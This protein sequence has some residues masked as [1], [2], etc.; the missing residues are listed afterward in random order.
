MQGTVELTSNFLNGVNKAKGI[1]KPNEHGEYPII[2]GALNMTNNKG[3][4]YEASYAKHFFNE[5]SELTRQVQKGVLRGEYGHPNQNSLTDDQYISRLLR[6]DEP[7]ACCTH[8]KIWLDFD[9][10][11]DATGR[12]IIGIMS[13]VAPYGPYGDVLKKAFDDGREEVC[14]SI[15][16]FSFPHRVGGRIIKEIRHIVTFDYVNEPGI[17]LATKYNSATLE[18]YRSKLFTEG[19]IREAAHRVRTAP[20]SNE[21]AVLPISN[22]MAALGMEVRDTQ[23]A[24][25]NFTELLYSTR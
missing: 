8:R 12:Q 19:A 24:R 25:R 16:C 18:S 7:S 22:F 3:E 5:A 2:V 17:I 15:R 20:G 23:H 21:S 1:I 6:I 10:Y 11:R 13:N 14:F 9:N 4:Y